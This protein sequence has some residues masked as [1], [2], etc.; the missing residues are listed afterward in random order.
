MMKTTLA[1]LAIAAVVSPA[2]LA[3]AQDYYE[4]RD[5]DR[6]GA[7]ESDC[8]PL[9]REARARVGRVENDDARDQI[10]DTI[11]RAERERRARDYRSCANLA[12][13]ALNQ[14]DRNEGRRDKRNDNP[15]IP[16][17]LKDRRR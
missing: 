5:L 2:T 17:I 1:G 3:G 6:R 14:I 7:Y 12:E 4:R 13:V 10:Q 15:L 11:S 8:V 9:L 16:D